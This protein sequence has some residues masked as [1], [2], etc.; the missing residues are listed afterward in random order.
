MSSPQGS[1]AAT[2]PVAPRAMAP[3]FEPGV[4]PPLFDVPRLLD[5]SLPRASM[6][7]A[8]LVLPAAGLLGLVLAVL[9]MLLS[10]GRSTWLPVTALAVLAGSAASMFVLARL[11]K[12][13]RS[14]R[15]Q[16]AQIEELVSLRHYPPAAARLGGLLARPM[17]LGQ[18][19][20]LAL[21]QLARVL[22]RYERFD[23]SIEV[24]D[25]ILVDP[26][27]DPATRF[28]I[29]CGRA[30]S[31][32]RGSRLYDAGE[33]IA[34]LRRE[35]T[36]LD[37]AVRRLAQ[38]AQEDAISEHASKAELVAG[39][40]DDLQLEA[41]DPASDKALDASPLDSVALTLVEL[42]RDVQTR[43]SAEALATLESKR[44]AL[45]DGLG[46][47]LADALALGSVAAH[48]LGEAG[49]AQQLWSEAT[50]LAPA[51]ELARRYPELVEVA[52]VCQSTPRPAEPR[53]APGGQR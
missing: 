8:L 41:L 21:I 11:A 9:L 44:I 19:R 51:I 40:E 15:E 32:L 30:M 39:L 50:C 33:A 10:P 34:Q 22:M 37:D 29:G 6:G 46:V 49:K 2:A 27:A 38:R 4:P 48:R 17:R 7:Q 36:R 3:G 42:Y 31:M 45:R 5:A 1:S 13:A 18:T 24:A 25:A 53:S 12:L 43:H 28:A 20:L 52:A 23:E 26:L 16:V 35:V 47:R 14:E